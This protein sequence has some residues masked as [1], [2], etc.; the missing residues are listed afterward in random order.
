MTSPNNILYKWQEIA[1][2]NVKVTLCQRLPASPSLITPQ[3]PSLVVSLP[4]I[5]GVRKKVPFLIEFL[6]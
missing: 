6:A 1:K 3:F 5:Q 4:D 2:S